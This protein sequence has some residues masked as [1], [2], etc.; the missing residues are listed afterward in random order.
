MSIVTVSHGCQANLRQTDHD[1]QKFAYRTIDLR[2]AR[3]LPLLLLL[4]LIGVIAPLIVL[5]VAAIA[6]DSSDSCC[7]VY[8]VSNGSEPGGLPKAARRD[9]SRTARGR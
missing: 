6:A 1:S 3:V 9:W 7:S 5:I 4:A 2:V 8:Q